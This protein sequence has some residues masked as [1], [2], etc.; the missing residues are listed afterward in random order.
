MLQKTEFPQDWNGDSIIE[1]LLLTQY[2]S[3]CEGPLWNAVRGKGLAYDAKIYL[4]PDR[5]CLILSLY[6][7]SQIAETYEQTKQ[8]VVSFFS[9]KCNIINYKKNLDESFKIKKLRRITI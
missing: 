4:I 1:T 5:K 3:Q 7:C 6:R 2:I 8:V 9:I